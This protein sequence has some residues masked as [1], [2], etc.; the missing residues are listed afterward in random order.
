MRLNKR[1]EEE[2]LP[3]DIPA[4]PFGPFGNLPYPFGKP[5]ST[6][7]DAPIGSP[8]NPNFGDEEPALPDDG[9][10]PGSVPVTDPALEQYD[11]DGDGYLSPEELNKAIDNNPDFIL[12]LLRLDGMPAALRRFIVRL[13][14]GDSPGFGDIGT[15]RK[16][17]RWLEKHPHWYPLVKRMLRDVDIPGI[18]KPF[19]P[20]ELRD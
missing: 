18:V 16:L 6:P 4:G 11:L 2:S 15:L 17:L 14:N 19:L 1:L 13:L 9:P 10:P 5:Y 12:I 3:S 20:S 8:S 7:D